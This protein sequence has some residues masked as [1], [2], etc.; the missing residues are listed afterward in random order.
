MRA[1]I[2]GI[3]LT[4]VCLG[5]G[6]PETGMPH[7]E[8]V[9]FDVVKSLALKKAAAEWPGC[10]LGT[11]LP[12]VDEYGR[13]SAWLVHFTADG[14]AFPD[15]EQVA[16]DIAAERTRL[17]PST[18]LTR[19]RSKYACMLVSARYDQ[20]P[21]FWYGYGT[22][23]YYAIGAK[24]LARAKQQIGASARLS[25]LYFINPIILLEF[26][27]AAGEH[28]IF[29]NHFERTWTS[30][31]QLQEYVA[32]VRCS[33][34]QYG[35]DP[36]LTA[37]L[38]RQEW[39]EALEQ[40][41]STFTDVFVPHP[42]LAPFYDW[43][44][45]CTPTAGAMTLGYI[46]RVKDFG[47]LVKW[48]MQRRDNVEGENDWQI[49]YTQRECAIAM[50]TDTN[51]GGTFLWNI[52]PGLQTVGEDNGYLFDVLSELGS[53]G[54]DWAWATI[55]RE[56][57]AGFNLEWSA[58]WEIHSLAAFG[59]R[60]PNK[61]IYVHN[62]WWM[63]AAWW[64]YSGPDISHVASPHPDNG[65]PHKLR[66]V[67][68]KG[69]TNYN[70][71]G[72]GEVLQVGDTVTVRWAND[73][74]P[75]SWVAIDLSRTGGKT[76]TRLDSVPDTGS[77]QWYIDPSQA[78]CDSC[79]LRFRQW[80]NGVF[81]SADGTFGC[82]RLIREPLPPQQLAPPNGRQ[83]FTPPVV[84]LVDST[85]RNVDSFE[86]RLVQGTDTIWREK[87]TVPKCSL[88][89]TLF[90]Y[91]RSYKWFCRAHNQYGWGEFGPQ[92]TF[93]CKFNQGVEEKQ[94]ADSRGLAGFPSVVAL[95]AG[96][97]EFVGESPGHTARVE[98]Y[99]AAGKR[100]ATVLGSDRLVWEFGQQVSPGLY[101]VRRF[102]GS[103]LLTRKLLIVD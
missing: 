18:D 20:T 100:V 1:I 92:W 88:P 73:G 65:D 9:P 63:P 56:I 24:A 50:Q 4:A 2:I 10:R 74:P 35:Y 36:V 67:Y 14:S 19:W 29:S 69:D 13:T 72:R 94:I 11:V 7:A 51:S 40:D 46:D 22:S 76:W 66:S 86:F 75:G 64:H 102:S 82:F 37:A 8:A 99:D 79:R 41:Y 61:D 34:L 31:A 28:V 89:D 81:T 58:I 97:V 87:T 39:A 44:Y 32:S 103:G 60:T 43:S 30:R 90:V 25:R 27:N 48:F 101:F 42:E 21:I 68:P 70:S 83:I 49:P 91:N 80:Y 77:Y 71:T 62:T 23:A 3:G 12:C 85:L 98:V 6:L 93:W 53:S 26:E 95:S 47:R 57:D 52:A 38:H 16:I 17:T 84:L 15:Y 96:R 5:I 55:T 78:K 54:N 33:A 45:G 59:Y